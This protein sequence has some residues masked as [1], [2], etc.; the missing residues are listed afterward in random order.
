MLQVEEPGD[1]VLAT[2]RTE[3][4]RTFVDMAFSVAGLELRWEGSGL[5]ERAFLFNRSD[6]VVVIDPHLFR[7]AEVDHLVGSAA[8]ARKVLGW[9]ATTDL[10]ELCTLM[11]D[12]DLARA[13]GANPMVYDSCVREEFGHSETTSMERV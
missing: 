12:A 11:V 7:P 9:Q 13:R 6:P 10:E 4:V 5:R 8:K 1:F 3:T 2:G